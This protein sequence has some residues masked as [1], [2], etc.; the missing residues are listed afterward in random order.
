MSTSDEY[1]AIYR[2]IHK[3]GGFLNTPK[4]LEQINA[5]GQSDY[6]ERLELLIDIGYKQTN[7]DV[8]KHF[9]VL[10]ECEWTNLLIGIEPMKPDV[11][12]PHPDDFNVLIS[13]V[14]VWLVL[15]R[16]IPFN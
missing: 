9:E 12:Y 10:S 14:S 5:L 15:N 7:F 11:P 4:C 16:L 2:R 8:W 1:R 3:S 6:E 13:T